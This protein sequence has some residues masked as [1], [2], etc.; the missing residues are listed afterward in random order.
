VAVAADAFRDPLE[1]LASNWLFG[2]QELPRN[3]RI[4]L[5]RHPAAKVRIGAIWRFALNKLIL[6]DL[7]GKV[8]SHLP[9]SNRRRSDYELDGARGFIDLAGL[10]TV[11]RNC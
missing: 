1:R 10:F 7:F 8:W 6:R 5:V 11:T 3:S 4:G 2:R 9:E